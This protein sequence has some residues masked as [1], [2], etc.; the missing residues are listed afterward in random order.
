MPESEV[1]EMLAAVERANPGCQIG[2]YPFFRDGRVGANF[3]IRST[4]A[5]RLAACVD[6][7]NERLRAAAHEVVAGGI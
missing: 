1:A 3:V 5:E 7:L 2:S 4:D 6:A